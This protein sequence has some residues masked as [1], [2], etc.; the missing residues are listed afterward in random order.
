LAL[1]VSGEISDSASCGSPLGFE[2]CAEFCAAAREKL[3]ARVKM[4]KI[5]LAVMT[6]LLHPAS[7]TQVMDCPLKIRIGINNLAAVCRAT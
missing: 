2:V 7:Q 1:P 5:V 6:S 3:G 4:R